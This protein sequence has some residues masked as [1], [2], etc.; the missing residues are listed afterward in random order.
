M[1]IAKAKSEVSFALTNRSMVSCD[2]N[3][4]FIR[5]DWAGADCG[6]WAGALLA[7]C[8]ASLAGLAA[9]I[10]MYWIGGGALFGACSILTLI[11]D[12]AAGRSL[13]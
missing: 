8:G 7:Y 6:A 10:W 4:E 2:V 3:L 11:S 9:C 1:A 13:M 5:D 12:G